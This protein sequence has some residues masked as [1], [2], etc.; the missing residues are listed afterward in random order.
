MNH[1][2]IQQFEIVLDLLDSICLLLQLI[3]LKFL[4]THRACQLSHILTLTKLTS[5]ALLPLIILEEQMLLWLWLKVLLV[6]QIIS[7][8]Y[9]LKVTLFRGS[10]HED[11][12]CIDAVLEGYRGHRLHW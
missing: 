11:G 8:S 9:R 5:S 4:R 3:L 6:R 12:V 10:G 7:C 2:L 1:N